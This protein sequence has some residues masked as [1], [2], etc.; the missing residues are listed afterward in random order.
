MP[1]LNK[2]QQKVYDYI[3]QNPGCTT[4]DIRDATW[5]QCPTGRMSEMRTLGIVF[6]EVGVE[7]YGRNQPF[8]KY[9][10]EEKPHFDHDL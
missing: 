2:Q 10:L 9:A 8:K 3:E 5:V 1:K 4:K 6:K 7:R